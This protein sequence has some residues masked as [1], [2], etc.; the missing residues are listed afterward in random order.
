M[1]LNPPPELRGPAC[2][3]LYYVEGFAA[4]SEEDGYTQ[5]NAG[6]YDPFLRENR[7]INF[8]SLF[9]SLKRLG[10]VV[11]LPDV[12]GAEEAP[13]LAQISTSALGRARV[14][15]MVENEILRW[16]PRANLPTLGELM[17]REQLSGGK[18][19]TYLG[20][21]WGKG[22]T[23]AVLQMQ[24]NRPVT[25][26]PRLRIKLDDFAL[27]ATLDMFVHPQNYTSTSAAGELS[28]QRRLFVIARITDA[29]LPA[30][31]AQAYAVGYLHD[32]PRARE[33][34]AD[35]FGAIANQMEV[36]VQQIDSFARVREVE[37]ATGREVQSL[38][39][40][41]EADIKAAFAEI[42]GEPFVPLDWGGETSDLTSSRVTLMGKPV[43]AAF[44]FKG[45]AKFKPMTVAD[46]GKNGD[47]IS[48]LFSEPVDLVVLQHCHQVTSAVRNHMRAFGTRMGKLRPFCIIDG[49]D[50]AR[51]L[52]AYKK[53]GFV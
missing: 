6:R 14:V 33:G 3:S 46:L 10:E 8:S 40:I 41:S 31:K 16:L 12:A 27:G 45:P 49:A 51:I 24:Q 1:S 17:A 22:S 29:T 19:F 28:G 38:R 37:A 48:R 39:H 35:P 52:K 5:R 36:F 42:I 43:A 26:E 25:N 7:M 23:A 53:L 20:P 30:L 44:A 11:T 2:S 15:N 21:V 18:L 50:T 47:Q 32:E 13:A 34:I 4:L 9:L